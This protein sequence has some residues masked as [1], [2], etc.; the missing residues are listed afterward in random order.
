MKCIAPILLLV[1]CCGFFSVSAQTDNARVVIPLENISA[2][3]SKISKSLSE[4]NTKLT[5]FSQTFNSNQGLRLTENSNSF[6]LLLKCS[7]APNRV[8]RRCSC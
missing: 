6:C 1:F 4:L 8:F 2:E 5:T 7:T 3:I